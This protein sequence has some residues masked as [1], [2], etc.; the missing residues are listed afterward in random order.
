MQGFTWYPLLM[1]TVKV[2][3]ILLRK[4]VNTNKSKQKRNRSIEQR[5]YPCYSAS[6]PGPPPVHDQKITQNP[7]TL[8]PFCL[9]GFSI[10]KAATLFAQ[11]G[12]SP[13]CQSKVPYGS[14]P[15]LPSYTLAEP[16]TGWVPPC[17]PLSLSASGRQQTLW[18]R[19]RRPGLLCSRIK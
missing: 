13:T 17:S 14:A 12:N 1:K 5:N 18:P 6:G 3:V 16:S 19:K 15:H 9:S 7:T 10:Q 8:R 11:V 2:F 4:K